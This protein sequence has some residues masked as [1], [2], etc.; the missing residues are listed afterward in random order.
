M[1]SIPI[2]YYYFHCYNRVYNIVVL[3]ICIASNN[4]YILNILKYISVGNFNVF[5]FV[6]GLSTF[7]T[8]VYKIQFIC[9]WN[10][11]VF[12]QL[13]IR[14]YFVSGD[15]ALWKVPVC[16][17]R[18]ACRAPAAVRWCGWR[19]RTSAAGPYAAWRC[20][21]APA[22]ALEISAEPWPTPPLSLTLRIMLFLHYMMDKV[23]AVFIFNN[24]L[25]KENV[26]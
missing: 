20:H 18:V 22:P 16:V 6:R 7:A 8:T 3:N 26:I 5:V 15:A 25:A 13:I 1:S 10:Y 21:A 17:T 4:K 12:S 19:C 9:H 23:C 11:L 14:I 24:L 2:Y